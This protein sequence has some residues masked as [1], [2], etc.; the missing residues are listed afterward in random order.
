MLYYAPQAWVSDDSDAVER[1][2]I[3]YGT[4]FCY[5]ISSMGAHVSAVPN[6]QINRTTPL[7]TRANVACFG[8]F[9]YEL[10]L[11]LLSD[12]EMEKVKRQIAFMKQH[13]SLIQDRSQRF[14]Q[15]ECRFHIAGYLIQRILAQPLQLQ[16][17]PG[18]IDL[19]QPLIKSS[20]SLRL[21]R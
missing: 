8:A 11:N 13:R 16:A 6:H 19:V 2:K 20:D 7:S 21:I 9:G 5:P 17:Q 18:R 15:I 3:Q 4:S 1:L 12:S 10:D 14:I